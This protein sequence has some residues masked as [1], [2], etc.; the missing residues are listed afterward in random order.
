MDK[1]EPSFVYFHDTIIVG[2]AGTPAIYKAFRLFDPT[3]I[4]ALGGDAN[5]VETQLKLIP[6]FDNNEVAALMAQLATYRAFA[7][8]DPTVGPL[9][10]RE[11][12]WHQ[13]QHHAG[14]DRWYNAATMVM[15]CQASSAAAERVFS[16]LKAAIGDQQQVKPT[17]CKTTRKRRSWRATTACSAVFSSNAVPV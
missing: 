2:M 1:V 13:R 17:A 5:A 14:L 8:G 9:M 3:R 12:W 4:D 10:D 11:D 16:M 6:F 7:I 15:I